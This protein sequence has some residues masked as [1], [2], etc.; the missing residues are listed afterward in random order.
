MKRLLALPL[1]LAV[2]GQA[3]GGAL[4]RGAGVVEA[5]DQRHGDTPEL[6]QLARAVTLGRLI[7]GSGH[8]LQSR[9]KDHRRLGP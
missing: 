4:Q 2:A 1:L 9:Q 8:V 7:K 3:G 6:L 5:G